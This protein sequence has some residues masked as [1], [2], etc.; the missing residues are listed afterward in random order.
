MTI[1]ESA[2]YVDDVARSRAFYTALLGFTILD[3]DEAGRF[4]ALAVAPGQVFLI[5]RK[6]ATPEPLEM[7]GG[8]I[9]PHGGDGSLHF[10]FGIP[11]GEFDAWRA[12]IEAAGT[13]VESVVDWPRGGRSLYFRDPD[14]HLVELITPGVWANY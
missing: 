11:A 4:T 3:A 9:P 12:R 10:A 8:M 1:V 6:G 7:P 5:F 2:I 14:G 13:A